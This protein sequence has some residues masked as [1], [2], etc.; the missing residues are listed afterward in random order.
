MHPGAE[1]N[2]PASATSF[3]WAC[4]NALVVREWCGHSPGDELDVLF[5]LFKEQV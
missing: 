2:E 3:Y 1:T 5:W 4:G